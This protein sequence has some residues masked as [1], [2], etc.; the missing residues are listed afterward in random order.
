MDEIK[1]AIRDVQHFGEEGGVVPVVDVAATSTFL[2]PEDMERVFKGEL[3]GRYLYSRH[4]N[5]TVH[6]FGQK[7][8]AMEGM[9]AAIGVASGISAI[10]CAIG[11]IMKDGGHLISSRTIYGGTYA[12]FANIL[13]QHGIQV[14]FVD[15]DDVKAFEKALTPQTKVIYT[16][17]MSNPLLGISDLK[18]LANLAHRNNAKLVVDNTF[19]PMLINPAAWGADVVI[20]SCTK[21]ISGGS[22]LIAGAIV[23]NHKFMEELIDLNHGMVMLTGPVM[24]PRVAHE[25]YHRLD[26][27]AIRMAA[28]SRSAGY[29]AIKMEEAGMKVIYPGLKKHPHHD[30][31]KKMMHPE[32]GFGGM[33]TLDCKTRENAFELAQKLQDEKFGLYAVSLGFSRT[34]MSCP[35]VST[36]SEIPLE[37]QAKSRL[38]PGLLRLSIGYTGSDKTMWERF[39]KCYQA[40][41]KK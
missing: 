34:L 39:I 14:T 5:P 37:E 7:L 3:H 25:L 2:V 18:A 23:S 32:Y 4:M 31:M 38:S 20:H 24:D 36:S 15:P 19:T 33:I 17:T 1:Q 35:A 22:D 27:L 40:V 10:Y 41:I 21:Y 11:Q 26:H 16:E 29:L 8:A 9:E 6:M 13:P 28:H 12:L 30:L